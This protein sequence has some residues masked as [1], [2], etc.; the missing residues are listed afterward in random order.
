MAYDFPASPTEGQ[1]YTPPG[2]Q[3][4]QSQGGRWIITNTGISALP[5][6]VVIPYAG[7]AAP[8]GWLLCFG[9]NV[10]RTTYAGLFAAIGTAHGAGDGSTTFGLPDLRGRV[11]A[12]KDDMGGTSANRITL[13]LNGDILGAAGGAETHTITEAQLPAHAHHTQALG[14]SVG[15]ESADHAHQTYA[16]SGYIEVD[17]THL[18]SGQQ[19]ANRAAGSGQV[20]NNL[21]NSNA[22]NEDASTSGVS[23]NHRHLQ[24]SWSGGRNVAHTHAVTKPAQWTDNAGSG[25]AINI[26]Q[27]T[28][29]L[30]QIIYA[31]A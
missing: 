30:N 18:F 13:S 15:T 31:G 16:W 6:G 24:D 20:I 3:T 23:A 11:V 8:A 26:V 1:L 25:T 28:M 7:A 27:P 12:G 5:I 17:H 2:G 21:H 22:G 10:S 9:Q 4:Y 14:C 29:T 19:G